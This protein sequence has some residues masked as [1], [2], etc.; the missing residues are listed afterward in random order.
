MK[1]RNDELYGP[2]WAPLSLDYS[3]L[4]SVNRQRNCPVC[5]RPKNAHHR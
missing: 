4:I 5:N 3:I 1:K 2:I